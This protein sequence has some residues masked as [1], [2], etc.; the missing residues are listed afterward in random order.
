MFLGSFEIIKKMFSLFIRKTTKVL[1]EANF[2]N[3]SFHPASVQKLKQTYQTG[4]SIFRW[5]LVL[6]AYLVLVVVFLD[7]IL[8]LFFFQVFYLDFVIFDFFSIC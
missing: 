5:P 8:K 4:I 2:C 7:T 3:Y 6:N 1:S